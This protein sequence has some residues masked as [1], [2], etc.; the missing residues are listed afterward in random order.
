MPLFSWLSRLLLLA[1]FLS[2][3]VA[4]YAQAPYKPKP[5][6]VVPDTIK[7]KEPDRLLKGLQ[8]YS[9]RR[10]LPAK[11]VKALFSFNRKQQQDTGLDPELIN[12]TFAEHDYK[13]V[14]NI[15][16]KTLDPFGYSLDD[17]TRGPKNI[18]AKAGN[19]IHIKTH[20]GRV[21][22]KLLFRQ[23]E[24]LE[25]QAIVESERLLRQTPH[26]Q[27]ARIRVN[28]LTSTADSVDIIVS[29]KDIFS[30]S[31]SGAYNA[32]KTMG[33][34]A[35]ND[36]NFLGLGHQIRNRVWLGIDDLPQSWQYRGG[37]TVENIYRTYITA[38]ANYFNDYINEILGF[39]LNRQFYATTTKYAGGT[40]VNWFRVRSFLTDSTQDLQ[41][42]TKDF[43]LARSYKLKSYNLGFE[44]PGRLIVGARILNINYTALPAETK[45]LNTT[46]YLGSVGYSYRKYYKDRYLFGFGRTEDVPAGNLMTLTLGY[47]YATTRIRQYLGVRSS[48]GKYRQ[49]FGYLYGSA[50]FGSFINQGNWEQGVVNTEVLYFTRLYNLN[51]WLIRNF[52]WNRMT[53]GLRRD[54]GEFVQINNYEGIRGFRPGSLRGQSKFTINLE[55]NLFTPISFIGFKLAGIL[56]TDIGWI[57]PPGKESP[58]SQKPY[59]GIGAGIR[60]RNEYI[61]L[62]N[63]QLLIAYYPRI[64]AEES[65]NN[66]RLYESSRRYYEF[67]DFYYSQPTVAPFR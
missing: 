19:H 16:I 11:A 31:G 56:F 9:K 43:W 42:N 36:L 59:Y 18:F 13:I 10:S 49:R 50:E 29:T 4:A 39:S 41:F 6:N 66:L 26:I 63:I 64:P 34:I 21:R 27:D 52:F 24:Q 5:E 15:E 1:C 37:Y 17:S 23:G 57:A 55:S 51:G 53:Y 65:F 67:Q 25:P 40:A 48:F 7:K 33:V 22:N 8:E 47:E 32:P 20:R 44:N 28:E 38:D 62:G 60:F 14:R 45:Y 35:L 12:Y 3:P 54:P 30:I 61:G 2:W 58:F 46:L